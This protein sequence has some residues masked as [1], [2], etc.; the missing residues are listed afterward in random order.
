MSGS[1]RRR[2]YRSDR[3]RLNGAAD[4]GARFPRSFLIAV[5]AA[6]LVVLFGWLGVAVVYLAA[7]TFEVG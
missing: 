2:L 7:E 3:D 5:V 4:R 6:P 1:S